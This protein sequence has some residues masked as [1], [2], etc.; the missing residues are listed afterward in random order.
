MAQQNQ[1]P[2]ENSAD[3]PEEGKKPAAK[4]PRVELHIKST[5]PT[6]RRAGH[7]FNNKTTTVIDAA[8]LTKDQIK[9]LKADPDL[10]VS[11]QE[12]K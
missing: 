4:T 10:L 9:T 11:E 8:E 5:R 1:A 2:A 6:Y 3:K 7:G 12:A